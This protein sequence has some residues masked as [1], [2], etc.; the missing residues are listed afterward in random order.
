[1]IRST[2]FG[3]FKYFFVPLE[4]H[5]P[6]P[7]ATSGETNESGIFDKRKIANLNGWLFEVNHDRP[8]EIP[9]MQAM[10]KVEHTIAISLQ[11]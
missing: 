7:S 3:K 2:L 10:Y 11:Y 6:R 9:G 8:L 4:I 5:K 1:M